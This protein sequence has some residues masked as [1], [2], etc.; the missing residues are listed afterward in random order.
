VDAATERALV[1]VLRALVAEGRTVLCVHHDLATVQEYF[2]HMLLLNVR[3]I[4]SGP[5][6]EV[7]TSALLQQ[8]YGGRLVDM[9]LQSLMTR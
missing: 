3:R 7:F 1:S 5:V 9:Q 4:A 8:A 2:D 6:S